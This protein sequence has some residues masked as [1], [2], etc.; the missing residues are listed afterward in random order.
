M[1]NKKMS[2]KKEVDIVN[3]AQLEAAFV[4]YLQR[5]TLESKH[6]R[7]HH[8]QFVV[9]KVESTRGIRLNASSAQIPRW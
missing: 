1:S 4:E 3:S 5:L 7:R 6:V 9:L 8:R 2:N